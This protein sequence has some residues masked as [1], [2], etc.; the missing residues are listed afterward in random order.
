MESI[1]P[2]SG[3]VQTT[4]IKDE[5]LRKI[6]IIHQELYCT[7]IDSDNIEKILFQ[8][9]TCDCSLKGIIDFDR[10]INVKYNENKSIHKENERI[11]RFYGLVIDNQELAKEI[12]VHSNRFS[13]E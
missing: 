6:A 12:Q 3:F 4:T 5:F 1:T 7:K 10:T 8:C 9:E 2:F 11:P 13:N